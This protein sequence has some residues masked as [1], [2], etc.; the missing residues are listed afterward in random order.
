MASMVDILRDIVTTLGGTYSASD[1]TVSEL[2]ARIDAAYK[3][4]GGS[5][6]PAVTSAD[7]GSFLGVSDGAWAKVVS[8]VYFVDATVTYES[9]TYTVSL[10]T[11]TFADIAAAAIA[12][13]M[14]IIKV[15]M[16][17]GPVLALPLNGLDGTEA[18][19]TTVA[20]ESPAMHYFE[21]RVTA[22]GAAFAQKLIALST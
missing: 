17:G 14:P 1:D 11:T 21:I 10:G 6:L 3:A 4:G 19:F 2:L 16:S 7:N 9:D 13:R 18:L 8:P 15:T 12:G 5:S 20:F 22:S